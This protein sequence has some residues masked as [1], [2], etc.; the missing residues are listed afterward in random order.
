MYSYQYCRQEEQADAAKDAGIKAEQYYKIKTD[1]SVDLDEN[2]GKSQYEVYTYLEGT[3]LTKSQ[4]SALWNAYNKGW[5]NNPYAGGDIPEAPDPDDVELAA[6]KKEAKTLSKAKA[7]A[8][9]SLAAK[10]FEKSVLKKATETASLLEDS[11][12][13]SSKGSSRRGRSCR[14]GGGGFG[15]SKRKQTASERKFANGTG[16]LSSV[17]LEKIYKQT[18]GKQTKLPTVDL[19]KIYEQAKIKPAKVP[20]TSLVK[21]YTQVQQASKTKTPT[22]MDIKVKGLTKAQ[23][24]A[25][26]KV[27]LKKLDTKR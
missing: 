23:K 7:R 3:D 17:D 13:G 5:K 16:K 25:M 15:S 20:T 19:I 26:L 14:R 22:P 1:K 10:A 2:G 21:A 27:M 12:S 18:Q 8:E 9:G 6:A 4:K 24:K 11:G